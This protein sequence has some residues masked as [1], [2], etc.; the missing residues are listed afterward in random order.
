MFCQAVLF[1]SYASLPRFLPSNFKLVSLRFSKKTKDIEQAADLEPTSDHVPRRRV[2]SPPS[3]RA[4]KISSLLLRSRDIKRSSWNGKADESANQ[5]TPSNA[6]LASSL[7]CNFT[8]DPSGFS[9][10]FVS[11]FF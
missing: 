3:H 2:D 7:E 4:S 9:F 11:S 10:F 5:A 6:L 8:P 1:L